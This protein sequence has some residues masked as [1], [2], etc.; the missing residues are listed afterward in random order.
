M[1]YTHSVNNFQHN[2]RKKDPDKYS[3]ILQKTT[4]I[5]APPSSIFESS[6]ILLAAQRPS[7][8]IFH[9][10]LVANSGTCHRKITAQG[11]QKPLKVGLETQIPAKML[12]FDSSTLWKLPQE[13]LK[14]S[15]TKDLCPMPWIG[16]PPR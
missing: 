4:S 9:E 11:I 6:Q 1:L 7:I 8:Q 2:R 12:T 5:T 14:R 10:R 3:P 13:G 15:P 16:F